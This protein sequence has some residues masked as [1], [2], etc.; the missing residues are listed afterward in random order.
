MGNATM[1]RQPFHIRPAFTLLEMVVV[2]AVLIVLAGI[3]APLTGSLKDKADL[4][5]TK[6]TLN[7][8]RQSIVGSD[9]AQGY[10]GDVG[11]LPTTLAA[12]FVAPT[13][14]P[15]YDPV[16]HHGWH[17]P[18][19][20]DATALYQVKASAGFTTDYGAAMDPAPV[21]AWNNPVI[22][23]FPS[24]SATTDPTQKMLFARLV[25]AGPDGVI[26]TPENVLYPTIAQRGDDVV[27]FLMRPDIAP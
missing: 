3:V 16:F 20:Q 2:L 27:L 15:A 13:G 18:Y 19:L 24:D 8:V 17:G 4:Q 26:Q 25:S 14:S 21:D 5:G 12:L 22:V 7:A 6:T 11:T 9:S 23:Q 10:L 1:T